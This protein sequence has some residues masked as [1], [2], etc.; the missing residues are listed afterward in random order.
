MRLT[1][2]GRRKSQNDSS[3]NGGAVDNPKDTEKFGVVFEL[4]AKDPSEEHK[5]IAKKLWEAIPHGMWSA[6]GMRCNDALIA[7][8]LATRVHEDGII[9]YVD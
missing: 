6:Y 5:E 9:I 1:R 2:L 3:M 8:G 7:L 4:L